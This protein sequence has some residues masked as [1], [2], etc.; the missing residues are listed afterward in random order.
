[1][2]AV[3]FFA[4]SVCI[5]AFTAWVVSHKL[6]GLSHKAVIAGVL[7]LTM[8]EAVALLLMVVGHV[9]VSVTVLVSKYIFFMP[10]TV[11]GAFMLMSAVMGSRIE[12]MALSAVGWATSVAFIWMFPV[13][14]S[15]VWSVVFSTLPLAVLLISMLARLSRLKVTYVTGLAVLLASITFD[16]IN[17]QNDSYM[18]LLFAYNAVCAI[19]HGIYAG[20]HLKIKALRTSE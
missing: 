12:A 10:L 8:C 4:I 16:G 17:T 11:A 15:P 1:M 14:G 2:S 18:F 5:A 19:V 7:Y 6:V 9:A 13:Y 3:I 20:G